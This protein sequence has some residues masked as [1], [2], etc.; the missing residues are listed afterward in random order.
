MKKITSRFQTNLA[1]GTISGSEWVSNCF[2][3]IQTATQGLKIYQHYF[4]GTLAIGKHAPIHKEG[5]VI[6]D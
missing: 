3:C 4:N 2:Y 1:S 5:F 6:V